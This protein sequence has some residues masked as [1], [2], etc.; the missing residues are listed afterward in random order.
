M[1]VHVGSVRPLRF[2]DGRPVRSASGVAVPERGLLVVQD[3]AQEASRP[4]PLR[5]DW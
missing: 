4:A 2:D 1:D 3:G 5:V